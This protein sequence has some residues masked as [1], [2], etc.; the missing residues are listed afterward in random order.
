MARSPNTGIRRRPPSAR[1]S[2]AS[3]RPP[4]ARTRGLLRPHRRRDIQRRTRESTMTFMLDVMS[5][6]NREDAIRVPALFAPQHYGTAVSDARPP[7]RSR[8]SRRTGAAARSPRARCS[9]RSA[10]RSVPFFVVVSGEIQIVRPSGDDRDAHRHPRP[11]QFTGEGNMI[12]G[13]R[14]LARARVSE[15]GRGDRARSASSCWR[16]CRPTPS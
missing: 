2:P 10:T 9:S 16:S 14:S 1:R 15:A 13:R 8:G 4:G 3:A 5:N 11:G 12:S 6:S 7:R